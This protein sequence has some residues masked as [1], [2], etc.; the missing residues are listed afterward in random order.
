MTHLTSDELQAWHAGKL[1]HDRARVVGHLA[2][3]A[4]C[5]AHLAAI[6][7]EAGAEGAP[8]VDEA[9][10]RAAG[11]RAGGI[12]RPATD[13]RRLAIA[14][15]LVMA[16][17]SAAYLST[18]RGSQGVTRG[19]NQI[20]VLPVSPIGEV[21]AASLTS[22]SWS[23]PTARARVVVVDVAADSTPLIERTTDGSSVTITDAERGRLVP[24]HT[25][26]WFV[27]YRDASGAL[28]STRT[29]RFSVR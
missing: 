11:Y 24:G 15:T 28:Q 21:S 6:E 14:A 25:Y 12:S 3:C 29:A 1:D 4:A 20:E 22:F 13:W 9:P 10:F 19:G 27:E 5:A 23:G 18:R 2:V 26:H 16:V 7:R 17:G 8:A